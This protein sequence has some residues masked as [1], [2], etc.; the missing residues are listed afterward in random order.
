[1]ILA[2][3]LLLGTLASPALAIPTDSGTKSCGVEWVK[4]QSLGRYT[5][6]HYFPSGTVQAVFYNS[7]SQYRYSHTGS[8]STTWKVTASDTLYMSSTYAYCV[9]YG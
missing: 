4:I 2:S 1:M 3:M 5:V 8:H 6:K 7:Y 9:N